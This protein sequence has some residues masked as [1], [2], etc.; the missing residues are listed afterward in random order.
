MTAHDSDEHRR[1]DCAR[2]ESAASIRRVAANQTTSG[3]RKN[4]AAS[5]TPMLGRRNEQPVSEAPRERT[6]EREPERHVS[7]LDG[8]DDGRPH[9][10]DPVAAPVPHAEHPQDRERHADEREP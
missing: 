6:G 3:Q 7:G 2:R 9:Q 1:T 5:A 4:F 8:G 10:R